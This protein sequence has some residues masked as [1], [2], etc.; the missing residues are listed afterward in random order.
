MIDLPRRRRFAVLLATLVLVCGWLASPGAADTP[1]APPAAAGIVAATASPAGGYWTTDAAGR[2]TA[3]DGA[4]HLGDLA[5]LALAAPV[6]GMAATPTGSG[7]WMVASDGGVFAFGDAPFLGSAAAF[8]LWAPVV[9]M[10]AT[11]TGLGYWMV[12]S[13]GGV[14]AFGDAGFLGSAGGM[15]LW[16]PVVDVAATPAGRGY[17]LLAGDGGVFSFGDAAFFGSNP[18]HESEARR[19]LPAPSGLGYWIAD[20]EG[21]VTGFGAA[22]SL[23]PPVHLT[24][25]TP[26]PGL[27]EQK[28]SEADLYV[29]A[30]PAERLTAWDAL[31]A[32]ES[33]GDW[34]IASGNGY[35]GGLQF[36]L[37]SWQAVG[38]QGF[39]HLHSRNEQ[40][41]RAELLLEAGGW[42][43][44]PSCARRLGLH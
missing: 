14:F 35:F 10:A 1:E 39:P 33:G 25:P 3:V 9:G 36:S 20:D 29:A 34:A 4:A 21:G 40:I 22:L 24:V 31:A 17:W 15:D 16:A 19:L 42:G 26:D 37:Q 41:Y 7:Y 6:V 32:C 18:A 44:W 28:P 2:V 23:V 5:S 13:D 11:P 43:N 8:E 30:L 38:G 27:V 12:A